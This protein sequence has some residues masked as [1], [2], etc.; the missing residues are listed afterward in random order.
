M[1]GKRQDPGREGPGDDSPGK[2]GA[3]ALIRALAGRPWEHDFFLVLRQL[4][5]AHPKAP[6]WGRAKRPADEPVRLG[7]APHLHFPPRTL[8]RLEQRQGFPPRLLS[9]FLGLFGPQGPLPLH[10]TEYVFER[11]HRLQDDTLARFA[12]I[13]HHRLLTLFYRAWAD[14]NPAIN[15]DRPDD[16]RFGDHLGALF[17]LGIASLY[18]RD[19]LPDL[20]KRHF[21]GH[22]VP[23]ARNPEGLVAMIRGYFRLPVAL[24]EFVP[25]WLTLGPDEHCL[26]GEPEGQLGMAVIGGRVW[27]CQ[28]Q[29]RLVMGPLGLD[30]YRR[31]LPGGDSLKALVALVR[32]YAGDELA[33]DVNLILR[34][35]EVPPVVLGSQGQLGW[36]TWLAPRGL[37]RDG[38]DLYLDARAY[39]TGLSPSQ[40]RP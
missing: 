36:T 29:F 6:R 23:Q 1:N 12:D 20:V 19:A 9:Y 25:H 35:Q 2:G 32:T 22:L 11:Q 39:E 16:D 4:E 13:F 30:D 27:Q 37:D 8:A 28:H 7:Q 3:E 40:L 17:G 21:A 15:F 33:F 18:H 10:L 31:L 24:E 26:L 14:P 38:D 5:C 34:R